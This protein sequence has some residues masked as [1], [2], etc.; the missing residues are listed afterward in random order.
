[1]GYQQ[2]SLKQWIYNLIIMKILVV[3]VLYNQSIE[4]S[5]SYNSLIRNYDEFYDKLFI[6]DNSMIAQNSIH[7]FD[8]IKQCY[9]HD[10]SNPGLSKVYNKAA[11]YAVDHN[12]EWLLLLD[13]DTTFPP[14]ILVEYRKAIKENHSVKLFTIKTKLSNSNKYMSPTIIKNKKTNYADSVP[15]GLTNLSRYSMINSGLMINTMAFLEVGGYNEEL[16]L[17]F[18][19]HEFIERFKKQYKWF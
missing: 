15:N 16:W 1:V 7:D 18:S 13:Q 14:N 6:Y 11:R 3:I 4:E 9:F 12:Y 17:D 19:D 2:K 8:G 10:P 5:N